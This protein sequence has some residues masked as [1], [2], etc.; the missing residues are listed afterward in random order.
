MWSFKWPFRGDKLVIALNLANSFAFML[1]GW[2]AGEVLRDYSNDD[3]GNLFAADSPFFF[4][5][6]FF[7]FL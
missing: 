6:F 1:Y 7:F 4:F 3:D 5:F 2:D